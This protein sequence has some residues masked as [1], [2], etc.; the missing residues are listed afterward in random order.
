MPVCMNV[1]VD[2]LRGQKMLDVD[3]L[4]LTISANIRSSMYTVSYM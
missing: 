1:G 3:L 4:G 2:S